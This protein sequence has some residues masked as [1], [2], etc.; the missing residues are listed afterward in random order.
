[1]YNIFNFHA[2]DHICLL[3]VLQLK[4]AKESLTRGFAAGPHWRHGPQT[5]VIGLYAASIKQ[6]DVVENSEVK[7][8]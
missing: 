6:M 5:P 7:C 1:M 8:Y 4:G 3:N 2:K